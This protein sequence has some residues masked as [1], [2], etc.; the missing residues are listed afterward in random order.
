MKLKNLIKEEKLVESKSKLIKGVKFIIRYHP[1]DGIINF[2]PINSNE[3]DKL[4]NNK[5]Q[6]K[7]RVQSY[8]TKMLR[9]GQITEKNDSHL[10]GLSYKLFDSEVEELILNYLK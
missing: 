7:L 8:L 2:M 9:I 1:K 10:T 4:N 6:I 3:L 5:E